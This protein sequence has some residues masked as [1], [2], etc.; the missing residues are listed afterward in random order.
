MELG[1]VGMEFVAEGRLWPGGDPGM[2]CMFWLVSCSCPSMSKAGVC[3]MIR[4]DEKLELDE[5]ALALLET[6]GAPGADACKGEVLEITP[7]SEN[8]LSS[9]SSSTH[10]TLLLLALSS[11]QSCEGEAVL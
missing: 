5:T 4:M 3:W 7:A 11:S 1:E 2:F 10:T 6:T 9:W 8:E